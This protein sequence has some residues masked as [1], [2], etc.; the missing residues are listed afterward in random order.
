MGTEH[1][2]RA[3]KTL[4]DEVA[5]DAGADAG[6]SGFTMMV[7]YETGATVLWMHRARVPAWLEATQG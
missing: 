7:D 2:A 6:F 5:E 3:A 4:F 1:N